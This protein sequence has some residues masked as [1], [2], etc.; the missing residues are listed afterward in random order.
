M[1]APP[2]SGDSGFSTGRL[3]LASSTERNPFAS[4]SAMEIAVE[5]HGPG[6]RSPDMSIESRTD[7]DMPSLALALRPPALTDATRMNALAASLPELDRYATYL[8]LL[9]CDHF[10]D[11]CAVAESGGSLLG[12]VTG[13]RKPAQP[14]TLFIWQVATSATARGKGVASALLEHVLARSSNAHV[15]Y[16]ETTV[17]ADNQASRRLF[18]GLARRFDAP[19]HELQGYGEELFSTSHHAEPLLRIGAFPRRNS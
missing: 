16:L 18:A 8:Y 1:D 2:P 5:P 12:F 3:P 14:D 11:S 10:R 7:L 19:L 15:R 6:A 4:A 17:A 9:L 13:Y